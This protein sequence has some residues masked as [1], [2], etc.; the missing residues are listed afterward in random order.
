[1]GFET[2][3]EGY[4]A[5]I[6]VSA[7]TKNIAIGSLVCIIVADAGSVAAFKDFKD[8]G[9]SAA[10]AAPAPSAPAPSAPAPAAAAPPPTAAPRAAPPTSA[11]SIATASGDRVYASP[12][13]KRLATERGLSLSVCRNIFII[14][15]FHPYVY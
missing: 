9:S 1:M 15:I 4:L 10:A 2:P 3:E 7:G 5:K 14:N 6:L 11:P 12:M 8:D 13:A